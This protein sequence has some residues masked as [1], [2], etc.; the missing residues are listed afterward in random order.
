M[1]GAGIAREKT[2]GVGKKRWTKGEDNA[3][4]STREG[5]EGKTGVTERKRN[6]DDGR[7]REPAWKIGQ[8]GRK[9]KKEKRKGK[10]KSSALRA[11]VVR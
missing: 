7:K 10:R 9:N 1:N 4:S 3:G 6:E 11:L 5:G 2:W 8:T